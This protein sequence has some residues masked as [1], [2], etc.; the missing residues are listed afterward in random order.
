M[1]PENLEQEQ[2]VYIRNL[3]PRDLEAVT[4]LDA[5]IMGRRRGE[6]FGIKLKQA[7]S[8]TGVMVSLAAEIGDSVVGFL[9]ARVYYGEFG[10]LERVASIDTMGVHPDFRRRGTGSELIGRAETI[11]R[12]EKLFT[13]TNESNA[14]MQALLAKLGYLRSGIIENLHEDD[15]ELVYLKRLAK[16]T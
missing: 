13:S 12:T 3:R 15:P 7:L 9:L 14:P 2:E 16:R 6:Y 8:D 4:E 10:A 1:E 5:K 11:C